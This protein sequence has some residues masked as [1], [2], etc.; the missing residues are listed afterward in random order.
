[1]PHML[2]IAPVSVS[3]RS[4]GLPKTK[5]SPSPTSARRL[6]SGR[7]S[8]FDSAR[9]IRDRKS[10]EPTKPTAST[11]TAT[12]ADRAPTSAPPAPGPPTC[13]MLRDASSLTFASTSSVSSTSWGR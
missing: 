6:A 4:S 12:G 7:T 11:R 1:M 2:E 8:G 5:R 13:A 9:R 10:A 3:A